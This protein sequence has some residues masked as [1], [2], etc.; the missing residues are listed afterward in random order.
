[1]KF[2]VIM[3]NVDKNP[4]KEKKAESAPQPQTMDKLLDI[5]K[6]LVNKY[7]EPMGKVLEAIAYR[8]SGNPEEIKAEAK[9]AT[10]TTIGFIA[11]MVGILIATSALAFVGRLSGET[12][13][14]IFG[15]AFGSIIT[16]LYRYLTPRPEED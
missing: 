4:E 9:L 2:G 16:F 13:A 8:I 12:V 1:M 14:F 6:D 3:A 10:Y 11:L 7:P 15:T 5:V